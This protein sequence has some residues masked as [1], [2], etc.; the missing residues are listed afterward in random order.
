MKILYL[1]LFSGISGDMF[2]G[3][4]IDLGAD[5][6]Y[7]KSE[8]K[9]IDIGD[10]EILL[11]DRK[12]GG[13]LSKGIKVLFSEGD[14][15]H[16]HY[17]D[18]EGKI[19][20]S[21]LS[22]S[23][24]ALSKKMFYHLAEAE[25]LSHG[26]SI[27]RV[28]F[29]EVG[30]VDSLV[31]IVGSAILLDFFKFDKIFASPINVGS[32]VVKCSHGVL[33]VPAPATSV[34]L[35]GM[36]IYSNGVNGELTTPTGAAILKTCVDE[37]LEGLPSGSILSIGRGGGSNDFENWCN[38]LTLY[39]MGLRDE[40]S[41]EELMVVNANLDDM[42][43][44]YFDILFEKLFSGGAL[45]VFL[46]NIFMKKNR[47]AIMLSVLCKR[48]D[49][50]SLCDIIFENS[51]TIGVRFY[52]VK[53][54]TL[55]RKQFSFNTSLGE[56]LIKANYFE[57][58]GWRFVPEYESLKKISTLKNLP[59]LKIK[60]IVRFEIEKNREKLLKEVEF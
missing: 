41:Y 52:E 3:G 46:E 44:Q 40:V 48:E 60:D 17:T 35:K 53:R 54:R 50:D 51:T 22:P 6:E 30:A 26:V 33:S 11:E 32:G 58:D 4:L 27:E 18:I 13:I 20:N 15:F 31:D 47:P 39:E 45:D 19:E 29:H 34:L 56:I 38:I 8:L 37:F 12:R 21:N 36:P 2:L 24:K 5:F 7:L 1:D 43:P 9:R 49:L 28:H 25:S 14:H 42:N 16:I 23:V 55:K 57:G 59:V 10:Y